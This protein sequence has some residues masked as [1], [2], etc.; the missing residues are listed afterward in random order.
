MNGARVVKIW[1]GKYKKDCGGGSKDHTKVHID[2]LFNNFRRS[3]IMSTAHVRNFC[4]SKN[5]NFD[6]HPQF[7]AKNGRSLTLTSD[8]HK[9]LIEEGIRILEAVNSTL[10]NDH[11]TFT[12][13]GN[14]TA[15][16]TRCY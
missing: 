12:I 1:C 16:D 2:N 8:Y 13:L 4:A 15:E 6:D 11:K 10:P 9:R 3:H 14:L 5:L 7:E